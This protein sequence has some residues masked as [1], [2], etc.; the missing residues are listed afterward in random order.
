[1]FS[2]GELSRRT[3]VKVPTIR[4]YEDI[5]LLAEPERTAGNQRR[6]DQD[7]LQRLNF[8]RHARDLG[9][10]I[11]AI[12]ALIDLQ[13]HPEK[14]CQSA[15]EIAKAQLD[16]VR[17]KL[18]RLKSLETE[19]ARIAEACDGGGTA[20]ACQVMSALADHSQCTNDH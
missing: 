10:S 3:K 7:G 19:L 13:D 18:A 8:I 1:M 16:D 12:T 5:G 17:A 6:Y 4:Y 2:I 15:G 20:G 11:E 9:F 14:P